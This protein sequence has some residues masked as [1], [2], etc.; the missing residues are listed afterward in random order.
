MVEQEFTR[1]KDHIQQCVDS[2]VTMFTQEQE[3]KLQ[4]YLE[5]HKCDLQHG[6]RYLE[7]KIVAVETRVQ[8]LQSNIMAYD[9]LVPG[10]H[11]KI[12]AVETL[13]Q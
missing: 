11:S 1:Q 12:V 10:L 8:G 9:T 5:S 6:M 7:S 13:V 4:E 2:W 3:R